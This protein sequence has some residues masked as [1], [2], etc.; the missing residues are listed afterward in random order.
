MAPLG[1]HV[2]EKRERERY[3]EKKEKKWF[4]MKINRL[5]NFYRE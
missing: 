5:L 4:K 1:F 3:E 2:G